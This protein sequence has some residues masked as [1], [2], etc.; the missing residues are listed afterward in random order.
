[1]LSHA[2]YAKKY[3]D[4]LNHVTPDFFYQP[5]QLLSFDNIFLNDGYNYHLVYSTLHRIVFLDNNTFRTN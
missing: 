3:L 5:F 1:M 2:K 4:L